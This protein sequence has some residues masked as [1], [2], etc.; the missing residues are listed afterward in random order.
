MTR[1]ALRARILA[2]MAD[3]AVA[4]A[5]AANLERLRP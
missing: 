3:R 1:P 4:A 2:L 5:I